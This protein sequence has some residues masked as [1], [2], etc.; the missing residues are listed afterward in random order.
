MKKIYLASAIAGLM[1]VGGSCSNDYDIYPV[2]YADVVMIKDAETPREVSV[3]STESR[4]AI[5]LTVMKGGH[6]S[7]RVTN[8]TLRSM[9]QAE[10]EAY[11]T[12]AGTPYSLLPASCFSFSPDAQSSSVNIQFGPE[13]TYKLVD[14]YINADA[15]GAYME[16]YD[17]SL[18]SPVMPVVLESSEATVNAQSNQTFIIPTYVVPSLGFEGG[19][20]GIV[21][22]GFNLNNGV[23]T[24]TVTLPI[25]NQWDITFSLEMSQEVLDAYNAAHGTSYTMIPDDVFSGLKDSYTMPAGSSTLSI[26]INIDVAKMDLNYAMPLRISNCSVNGIEADGMMVL[27]TR[28]KLTADMF[29]SNALEPTEGSFANLLD[30]DLSTY[31]HSAWSVAVSG[32]HW[33]EVTTPAKYSKIKV[34]YCNRIHGTPNAPAWLELYAGTSDTNLEFVYKYTYDG[35]GL[36]NQSGGTNT[37]PVVAIPAPSNVFR[38]VNTWG[39]NG[40]VFFVMTEFRLWAI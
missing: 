21:N 18:Y 1:L 4:K 11:R 5:Q 23:C 38:F 37:L 35:D 6:S 31:F 27:D 9:D 19:A 32:N 25:E 34:E 7:D 28:V 13:E 20:D 36:H 40:N 16:D 22:R 12:E 33:I 3:Y 29:S 2:E 17:G 24:A 39:W 14:V 10:F 15:F 8:V 30:D 26:P